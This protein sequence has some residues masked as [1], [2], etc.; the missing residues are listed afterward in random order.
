[1]R[2]AGAG[3]FAA[4]YFSYFAVL[5]V[6]LPYFNLYCKSLGFA[7][8]QIGALSMV[9]PAARVISGFA[10]IH[11][12]DRTRRQRLTTRVAA[13]G[14]VVASSLY[15]LADRFPAMLLCMVVYG[16]IHVPLLPLVEAV[17]LER[18]TASR[19]DYARIRLWGTIGFI[20]LSV[21][22]GKVVAVFPLVSVLVGLVFLSV[23]TAVTVEALP[24]VEHPVGHEVPAIFPI[25]RRP[26]LAIFLLCCVLMQMSHGAYYGFF[27]IYMESVGVDRTTIGLLWG[28]A[29][30]SELVVM[31]GAG[32]LVG[33]LG[34]S[35]VLTLSLALAALR[36]AILAVTDAMPAVAAAQ[37]L[38]AFTFGTF[39]VAAIHFTHDAFPRP[40]RASGQSL[41]SLS[42]YGVG[43]IL[44]F[45]GSG[46][47]YDVI[48][49]RGL[50]AASCILAL[51]AG[52]ASLGLRGAARG[53]P[54][55]VP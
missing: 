38:H 21:G 35:R 28:L 26:T 52:G 9:V 54:T 34:E 42:S 55:A 47:F 43:M 18:V 44:G 53:R 27:S 20:C 16:V 29:T 37:V 31:Y 30:I 13:W 51:I 1:V 32:W 15:L 11:W 2:S 45:G 50:F 23:C 41:Y 3:R 7:S 39:H 14:S 4:F 8:W 46:L 17:T 12:A 25:L 6:F 19:W 10:L 33:R 48:G 36:W 49:P 22:F 40:L 5:G 24:S